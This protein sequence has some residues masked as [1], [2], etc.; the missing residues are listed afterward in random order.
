MD[1]K[2]NEDLEKY[3][4]INQ[5]IGKGSSGEVYLVEKKE[6]KE[7]RELKNSN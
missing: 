5:L 3:C 4:D 1:N 7:K 2:I 6:T